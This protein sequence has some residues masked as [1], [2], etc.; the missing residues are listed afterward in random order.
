MEFL[1]RHQGVSHWR[2]QHESIE[3]KCLKEVERLADELRYIS[4]DVVVFDLRR[5]ALPD[6]WRSDTAWLRFLERDLSWLAGL[7]ISVLLQLEKAPSE[8]RFCWRDYSWDAEA[9]YH[10]QRECKVAKYKAFGFQPRNGGWWGRWEW[11]GLL[12]LTD[13]V[14]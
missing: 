11:E 12:P 8:P 5:Q 2:K 7:W 14:S 4:A 13:R 1:S 3:C 10:W 9:C 6:L